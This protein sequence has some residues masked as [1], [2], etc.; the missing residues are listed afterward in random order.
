MART[1]RIKDDRGAHYHVMSR[2]NNRCFLFEKGRMKGEI[3]SL[4]RRSAEFSG[5]KLEAWCVLDN[6]FHAVCEVLKPEAPVPEEEVLRRIGVLKGERFAEELAEHWREL[7]ARGLDCIVDAAL[8]RWRVRMNDV[9]QFMKTFKELV[10]LAYKTS[11]AGERGYCGSIWSG[12]FKSTLVEAGR[13]LATC[14]RYVEL[15]PVR[16][17]IV[18]R[19]RDYAY[20]SAHEAEHSAAEPVP[21]AALLRRVAQIGN[22]K[23]FGSFAFVMRAVFG[24]GYCFAGH[25]VPRPVFAGEGAYASHGWKNAS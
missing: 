13:H 2:T 16:A 5:V 19:A 8:G 24:F 17:G 3:V 7:H 4:L 1:G 9:S 18:S 10:N 14:I 21:E 22:G 20:G 23:V 12:R 25:P 6:H 15:N 11:D